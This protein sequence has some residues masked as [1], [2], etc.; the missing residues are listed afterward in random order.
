MEVKWKVKMEV[1]HFVQ[2]NTVCSE[3]FYRP[4]LLP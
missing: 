2:D 3:G 1:K 4:F